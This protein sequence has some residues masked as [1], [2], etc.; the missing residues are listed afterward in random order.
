[1]PIIAATPLGSAACAAPPG[2]S[3]HSWPAGHGLV[4]NPPLCVLSLFF[5]QTV[6]TTL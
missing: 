3:R 4:L 1:M 5:Q 2:R 6:T